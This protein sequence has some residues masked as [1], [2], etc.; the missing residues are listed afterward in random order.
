MYWKPYWFGNACNHLVIYLWLYCVTQAFLDL[1][2][3]WVIVLCCCLVICLCICVC[4]FIYWFS[5][6]LVDLVMHLHIDL[7]LYFFVC[8]MFCVEW[9]ICW[10]IGS[11]IHSFTYLFIISS[12]SYLLMYRF[13]CIHVFNY[14]LLL[15]RAFW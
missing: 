10:A 12:L 9:F 4:C 11:S 5:Y 6:A 3:C 7:L 8:I 15:C 14:L 1:F 2:I 13:I